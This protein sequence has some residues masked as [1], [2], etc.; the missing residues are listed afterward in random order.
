MAFKEVVIISYIYITY[1][2]SN[3]YSAK[4]VKTNQRRWRR[5]TRQ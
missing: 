4:I 2:Q 5:V 3:L 1:I